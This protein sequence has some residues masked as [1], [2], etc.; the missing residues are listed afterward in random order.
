[1]LTILEAVNLSTEYLV[2]KG[3]ESPRINAELL[4]AHVLNCSRLDLYLHF[5]RPLNELELIMYRELLKR[6][7]SREPLQHIIG[8]VE[9]YGLKFKVN[10]DVLIPR[11]ETELLVEEIIKDN[12]EVKQPAVL[13]IGTGSG[14]IAV[15]LAKYLNSPK[16]IAIDMSSKAL[17]VAKEN[18]LYNGVEQFIEFIQHDINL[19]PFP[20]QMKFDIIVSNPPYVSQNDYQLLQ[21]ELKVYEPR[22]ALTDDANGLS[23]YRVIGSL[24]G[25]LLN[26]GGKLYF[27]LGKNQYKSVKEILEEN[28]LSNIKIIN[29]YQNIERII[30]GVKN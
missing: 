19:L 26:P 28:E 16:M 4:L 18:S 11:P 8:W 24:S 21:P 5:D 23:Y 3:I 7:G 1:M 6:R 9:F 15:S 12:K 30:C 17:E 10:R 20:L 25:T 2:K 22:K 14:N 29:D 13:D 27:E